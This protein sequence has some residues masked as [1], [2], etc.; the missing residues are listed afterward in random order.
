[1]SSSLSG[2]T[3]E[4]T[5]PFTS[6]TRLN[7]S[8]ACP[9]LLLSIT[10]SYWIPF[11][12]LPEVI[13]FFEFFPILLVIWVFPYFVGHFCLSLGKAYEI[14]DQVLLLF[15]LFCW[16]FEF[17]PILLVISVFH[18]GKHMK[19]MIVDFPI[20]LVISV[21]HSGKHIKF[22]LSF[23]LFCLSFL[24]FTRESIWNSWSLILLFLFCWSF[25]SFTRESMWNS[26]SLIS[27]FLFCW[28]FLS[29]T[30]ESIWN[31]WSLTPLPILLVISDLHLGKHMKFSLFCWSFWPS[32]GKAYE[33]HD[34]W[35][36]SIF[37][38]SFLT[39]TRESIWNSCW[40]FPYW[41]SLSFLLWFLSF[42][43]FTRSIW[44]S[45]S[46]TP[47]LILLVISDLH[48]RKH[49]KFMLSFSLLTLYV[50]SVL[51]SVFQMGKHMKFMMVDSSPYFVGHFWPS[52]GSVVISVFSVF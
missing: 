36:L 31:S 45:W 51:I 32:L 34:R 1:M 38:W 22:M 18:S 27:L 12:I 25:L 40:V 29:F 10:R 49:M 20:L 21:F 28:S 24:S 16:S 39:F 17:F 26:W 23:S 47:L 7:N 11:P 37:C 43:T 35:L 5:F 46:L 48:S 30:R 8:I 50:I 19:F 41:L 2:K 44:N 14:H 15:S 42:M 52:L 13:E 3:K 4:K 33:I 6:T 9:P